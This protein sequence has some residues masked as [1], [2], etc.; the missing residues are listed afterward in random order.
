M[1]IYG[2]CYRLLECDIDGPPLSELVSHA[3]SPIQGLVHDRYSIVHELKTIVHDF[4]KINSKTSTQSSRH[5]L[6]PCTIYTR[7]A[8]P[9]QSLLE[10]KH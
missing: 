2:V 10:L 5:V 3:P 9:T 4:H 8:Q 6:D 1:S 7:P